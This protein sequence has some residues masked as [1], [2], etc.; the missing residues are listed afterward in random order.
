M[1]SEDVFHTGVEAGR[2]QWPNPPTWMSYSS[3]KEAERCPRR[4]ALR[5]ATYPDIWD[6]SGY[7]DMP[8]LPALVG[9]ITHNALEKILAEVVRHG[10][11]SPASACAVEALKALGGYTAVISEI[12][13]LRLQDFAENPRAR[14]RVAGL[15]TAIRT[16]IPEMRHRVQAILT[17]SALQS[18]PSAPMEGPAPSNTGANPAGRSRRSRL[19]PGS[20]PEVSLR[21]E[22]IRW[23]GR[24]DLLTVSSGSAEIVDYKTG[25]PDESHSEQL[26]IYALIWYRDKDLNPSGTRASS[27]IIAYPTEDI[28]VEAPSKEELQSL[29][30]EL[31]SR[32]QVVRDVLGAR[33]PEARPSTA[34][35]STCPVRQLCEEYWAFLGQGEA[36]STAASIPGPI[37]GDVEV[38]VDTRNGP[39]SWWALV[40][41]GTDL[42][43]SER[44]VLRTQTESPPFATGKHARVVNGAI[45]RDDDSGTPIVTLT[46]H[47]ELFVLHTSGLQ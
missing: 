30:R 27:L 34:L 38:Q 24:A 47:S 25:A 22:A 6:G 26:R 4:W 7:P 10:C 9:D 3:L 19:D 41:R 29:E 43:T 45:G 28:A 37:W 13:D 33:P 8:S 44:I 2:G 39:R 12:A 40:T 21:A 18:P 17:R 15:R 36:A 31:Q 23:Q 5:R 14:D 35:C 46:S 16:R 42:P 1:A 11:S 32:S 20:H